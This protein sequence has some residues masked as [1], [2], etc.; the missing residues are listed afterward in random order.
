[1]SKKKIW[2]LGNWKMN[3]TIAEARAFFAALSPLPK[4]VAVGLAPSACVLGALAEEELPCMRGAQNI[5]CEESGAFTGELS[6]PM[7]QECKADFVLIGHSER[8]ALFGESDALIG[9]KVAY[10]LERG[11][12]AVLCVGETLAERE[13]GEAF[14]VVTRQLKIALEHVKSAEH[15]VIAYEPVWA[16]GTGKTASSADAESVHAHIAQFLK[17]RFAQAR[18][19]I[20]YGGSV[21]PA[22]CR[23]LIAQPHIDGALVGGASL[24]ATSFN[25]LIEAAS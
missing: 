19:P 22:N 16:I 15:L 7:L 25:A 5:Y 20:L 23:E 14:A 18:V 1:M 6:A 9:K 11:L 4:G 21:K 2:L 3:H 8:R 10:A 17:G 13:K 24:E 12:W